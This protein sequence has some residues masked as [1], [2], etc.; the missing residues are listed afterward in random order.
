MNSDVIKKF[1]ESFVGVAPGEERFEITQEEE[2]SR[3]P[4]TWEKFGI[5]LEVGTAVRYQRFN[6]FLLKVRRVLVC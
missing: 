1:D 3:T 5:V 2:H 6:C 4:Q